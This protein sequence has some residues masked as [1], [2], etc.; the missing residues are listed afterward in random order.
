LS[1]RSRRFDWSVIEEAG[2]AHG[3]DMAA[4]LQASHRLLLIGDHHQL[5]PYN[6]QIFKDLL[7]DPLRIRK[8]VQ[9]G[10]QF[11]PGLVDITIVDDDVGKDPFAD[12]CARWKGMVTLFGTIFERSLD[13]ESGSG[14]PAATLSDQHRMHPDIA[15]LVGRI[16]YPSNGGTLIH[17]PPEAR[18]RFAGP[19]P[20][21]IANGSWLPDQR[22]VWRDVPWIQKT[23]FAAGEANGIFSSAAETEAVIDTLRQL[24]PVGETDCHVQ[25]LSPYNDQLLSIRRAIEVARASGDLEWMFKPPFEITLEKRLG[26]TVDQFQGS[27]ADIV[28]VSLVR[29]NA[30]VPW[31]S[32]GFLKEA[33]RMNVLLSRAKHKLVIVGSWDFF[34]SRCDAHTPEDAEYAYVGRMM[35]YMEKAEKDGTLSRTRDF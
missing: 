9:V 25:I 2:K 10:A 22:I 29:N 17:T 33:T 3:F 8:A 16:F 24:R 21:A 15:D 27:E 5:P 32:L 31:K 12:R 14:G 11:A 34:N 19:P 13:S 6:A 4:A 18:H 23:M 1:R 28:I 7:G 35:R 20:Y 30:L 26:A